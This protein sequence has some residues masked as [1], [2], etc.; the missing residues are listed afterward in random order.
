MEDS[1]PIRLL[2]ME[3]SREIQT[4]SAPANAAP[5][6]C[7]KVTTKNKQKS[8]SANPVKLRSVFSRN[9]L[10]VAEYPTLRHVYKTSG[11]KRKLCIVKVASPYTHAQHCNTNTTGK[12]HL[13]SLEFPLTSSLSSVHQPVNGLFFSQYERYTFIPQIYCTYTELLT[14]INGTKLFSVGIIHKLLEIRRIPSVYYFTIN[15]LSRWWRR[16]RLF[17]LG[18]VSGCGSS[19]EEKAA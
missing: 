19:G 2:L 17:V 15:C 10:L 5:H 16:T 13:T 7:S 18:N 1:L 11:G 14:I 3:N 12:Q 8:Y 9:I 6:H 4:Y